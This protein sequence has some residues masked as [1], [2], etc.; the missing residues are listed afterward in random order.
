[1]NIKNIILIIL[2]LLNL[3]V[4][5]AQDFLNNE[6]NPFRV[7]PV[8]SLLVSGEDMSAALDAL[9]KALILSKSVQVINILIVVKGEKA[10]S[11]SSALSD[12]SSEEE[13]SLPPAVK[14][15]TPELERLKYYIQELKLY[16][17]SSND[18]ASIITR[19]R[20]SYSPT[21]I[22]RYE[23]QDYVYEGYKN[24]SKY[25]TKNGEFNY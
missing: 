16:N 7:K 19:L 24:I 12:G 17:A 25:F 10:I 13:I 4:S 21:W 2:F 20:L 23:G 8:V 1:M 22:V 14:G 6:E 9:D 18:N 3:G 11:F 5:Q 15:V